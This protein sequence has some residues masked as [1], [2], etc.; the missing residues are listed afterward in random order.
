[1]PKNCPVK[2]S[3][4][5]RADLLQNPGHGLSICDWGSMSN[6]ASEESVKNYFLE[7]GQN[8]EDY[9]VMTKETMKDSSDENLKPFMQ[10]VCGIGRGEVDV[11]MLVKVPFWVNSRARYLLTRVV[12][13]GRLPILM[14]YPSFRYYVQSWNQDTLRFYGVSRPISLEPDERKHPA[15]WCGQKERDFLQVPARQFRDTQT[16]NTY[17]KNGFHG[18]ERSETELQGTSRT[19]PTTKGH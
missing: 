3:T 2:V 7:I 8:M 4:L 15:F 13:G 6:L 16:W 5:S 18:Q 12:E 11:Q 14:G 17:P 9:I 10:S 19:I 1:M